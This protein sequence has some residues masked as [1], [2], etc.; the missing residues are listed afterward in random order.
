MTRTLICVACSSPFERRSPKGPVPRR[1]PGCSR[2]RRKASNNKNQQAFY[3]RNESYR[4]GAKLRNQSFSYREYMDAYR[5]RPEV[6]VRAASLARQRAAK[7]WARILHSSACENAR[8]RGHP[9]PEWDATWLEQRLIEQRGL[10]H[11]TGVSMMPSA[12]PRHPFKPSPERLDNNETYLKSNTVLVTWAANA[13]R[14]SSSHE[15]FRE[16][17]NAVRH[18]PQTHFTGGD[19]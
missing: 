13:A 10:C 18:A 3:R 11:Y 4:E 14:C 1:C 7:N 17:L 15:Q 12:L 2:D 9:P 6:R 5:R 19:T 16:W 8:R